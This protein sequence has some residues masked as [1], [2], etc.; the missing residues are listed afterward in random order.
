M[1]VTIFFQA[2]YWYTSI[3]TQRF[4]SWQIAMKYAIEHG[5]KQVIVNF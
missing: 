5:A 4:R 1:T 2:G 3:S